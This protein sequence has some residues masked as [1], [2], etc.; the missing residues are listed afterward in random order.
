MKKVN[1]LLVIKDRKRG[2]NNKKKENRRL[3]RSSSHKEPKEAM[4]EMRNSSS[5]GKRRLNPK[6]T[7]RT[8][9]NPSKTEDEPEVSNK[10]SSLNAGELPKTGPTPIA[11]RLRTRRQRAR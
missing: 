3:T 11:H 1:N 8:L 9:L 10:S 2:V 6:N 4:E 5:Q 7:S